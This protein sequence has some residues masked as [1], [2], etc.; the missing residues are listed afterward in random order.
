ME[1]PAAMDA[2]A[3]QEQPSATVVDT[4]AHKGQPN[5]T[6]GAGGG[7]KKKKKSKK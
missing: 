7:G 1:D 5:S 3:G 6:G 4:A 2:T